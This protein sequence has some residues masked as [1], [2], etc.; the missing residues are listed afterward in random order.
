M[1]TQPTGA[2]AMRSARAMYVLGVV[3]LVGA[4][5]YSLFAIMDGVALRT[6]AGAAAVVG[7]V[8]RDA[9]RT[10]TT[11]I[12]NGRGYVVPRTTPEMNVVQLDLSGRRAAHATDR[13]LYEELETGDTVHVTYQRRRI[14]GAVQILDLRR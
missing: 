1:T 10:Y 8:H 9:A 6:D 2:P 13:A 5:L 12:I 14:T 7:K 3:A 4:G 11:E